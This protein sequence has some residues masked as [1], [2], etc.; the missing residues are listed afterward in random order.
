MGQK[1]QPEPLLHSLSQLKLS[2]LDSPSGQTK[3]QEPLLAAQSYRGSLLLTNDRHFAFSK[4][5]RMATTY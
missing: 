1:A 3:T 4:V 5:G 2:T